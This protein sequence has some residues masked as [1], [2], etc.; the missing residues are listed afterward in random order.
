MSLLG[1]EDTGKVSSDAFTI[2]PLEVILMGKVIE[3][4]RNL[5]RELGSSELWEHVQSALPESSCG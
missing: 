4:L 3:V 5:P 2:D 1:E